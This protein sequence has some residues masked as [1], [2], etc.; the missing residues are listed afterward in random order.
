MI[1][2]L[3]RTVE[4]EPALDEGVLLDPVLHVAEVDL[5]GAEFLPVL[6]PP[7]ATEELPLAGDHLGLLPPPHPELVLLVPVGEELTTRLGP[8]NTGSAEFNGIDNVID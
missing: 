1:V 5:P 4:A 7:V 2:Q 8:I 6:A 3:V